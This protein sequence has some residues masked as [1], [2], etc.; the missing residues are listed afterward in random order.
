MIEKL[1]RKSQDPVWN[2]AKRITSRISLKKS[3]DLVLNRAKKTQGRVLYDIASTR[4]LVNWTL[5]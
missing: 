1:G 2:L 4:I 5:H 3:R